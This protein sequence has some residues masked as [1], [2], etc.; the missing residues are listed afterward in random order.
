MPS[1]FYIVVKCVVPMAKAISIIIIITIII[2]III[3]I[4]FIQGAHI[5]KVIFNG[6]LQIEKKNTN[7][8]K[9]MSSN[10]FKTSCYL[11]FIKMYFLF[12]LLL[13][14]KTFKIPYMYIY[15]TFHMV[16]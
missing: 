15:I 3:I 11:L 13:S 6:A 9:L 4:I 14:R 2:I 7:A 10:H 1:N 5:T 8:L 16:Y 12:L